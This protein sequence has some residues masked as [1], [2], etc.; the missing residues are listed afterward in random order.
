MPLVPGEAPEVEAPA[1]LD[2]SATEVAAESS[3]ADESKTPDVAPK[4]MLEAVQAAIAPETTEE[5]KTE[6]ADSST[7]KEGEEGNGEPKDAAAEEE[8]PFHKHPRWQEVQQQKRTLETRV[9]E[10]EPVVAEFEAFR[11]EVRKAG[12]SADEVNTLFEIGKLLKTDP[13]KAWIKAKP[14]FD[15]MQGFTGD[16]LP[17]D[18]AAKVEAGALDQASAKEIATLRAT[19]A[20]REQ[21]EAAA[22]ERSAADREEQALADQRKFGD[23]CAAAVTAETATWAKTDPDYPK[24]ATLIHDRVMVLLQTKGQDVKTTED[25]VKLA[26]EAKADV[27][28]NL[29][30][31]VGKRP[32]VRTVTGGSSAKTTATPTT[33]LE[34]MKAAVAG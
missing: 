8:P 24:K 2:A 3:T 11:G 14:Y 34:A 4:S 27:E 7:A 1:V 32:V 21:S 22:L 28:K 12:M 30:S 29:G 5:P 15:A 13:A 16:V 33:L 9:A 20:H 19:S 26:R 31:I 18:L 25:A 23:S 10:L 6:V 17:D